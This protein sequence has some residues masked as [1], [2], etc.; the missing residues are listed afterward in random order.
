MSTLAFMALYPTSVVVVADEFD[1]VLSAKISELGIRGAAITYFDKNTMSAPI[2]R[3]YGKVSSSA[4]SRDVT[5]DT[6]FNI[7]S[8]SKPF[9]A[10]AIAILVDRGILSSIDDDICNV[11]PA[12]YDYNS[13]KMMCRNPNHP[14]KVITWR[15]L[16]THRS[17]MKRSL[18]DIRNS[19]GD[20]VE[21]TSG[22]AGSYYAGDSGNP[23]CPLDGVID[24]YR[25][26]LTNDPNA[27]TSV[28]GGV[29]WYEAAATD[30]G[31]WK[32][33]EPGAGYQYSNAAYGYIPA[34]I[35]L[36][37]GESFSDFCRENLFDLLG[38]DTTAWHR[39]DLPPGT[40]EAV[41]VRPK[42][43]GSGF[44][45]VG[46]FCYIEYGSGGLRTT[47]NDLARWGDAL[48]EYGAP[49][50][51]S[52]DMGRE[53]VTC[54]EEEDCEFGYGWILLENSMKRRLAG[55]DDDHRRRMD[56]RRESGRRRAPTSETNRELASTS[57]PTYGTS[58]NESTQIP[59][60]EA[61]T[62]EAP[63][64]EAPTTGAPTEAPTD[65]T[66]SSLSSSESSSTSST[67]SS[68]SNGA[69]WW[70]EEGFS[71][72][73]WTDGMW[74]DG[75]DEG[76]RTNMII[77]PKAGVYVAVLLNTVDDAQEAVNELTISV[78]RDAAAALA[79]NLSVR[80]NTKESVDEYPNSSSSGALWTP[81]S[82][83]YVFM[84]SA[85]LLVAHRLLT[86]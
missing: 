1:N 55:L 52:T 71:K 83:Q 77:L 29:N 50:L 11:I 36:A 2:T 31:V 37:T 16:M 20:R 79:E 27:R 53:I 22:P 24:F 35:E 21:A 25:A 73:D 63:T 42:K 12:E 78:V 51:W 8:I 82:L 4:S 30:G 75:L 47:A 54:Q 19:S 23:T 38:M 66:S 41:P 6:V 70:V 7:A 34:L 68:S 86:L 9:V 32:T 15:M 28:G 65:M 62:T 14:D 61:P 18:P 48:L 26:L 45:D 72:Y 46:H 3:G 56:D 69:P 57:S 81:L 85:L 49:T 33:Y 60:T 76:V 58:S 67:S 64:T 44:R 43:N 10:S 80:R 39:N 13:Q 17:S 59:T 5:A 40:L 84:R 74:H